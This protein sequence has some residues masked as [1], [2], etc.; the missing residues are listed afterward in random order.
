VVIIEIEYY[1]RGRE[2]GEVSEVIKQA[3]LDSGLALDQL[4]FASSPL[5]GVKLA[6][7]ELQTGDLGLFL[8]LAE[9][10]EVLRFIK[11]A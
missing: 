5:Q 10:D 1:L 6:I 4:H 2:S 11:Q 8:I 7:A 9:R 3:C